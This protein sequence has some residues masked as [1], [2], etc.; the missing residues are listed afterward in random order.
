MSIRRIIGSIANIA[1]SISE[2][3]STSVSLLSSELNALDTSRKIDHAISNQFNTEDKLNIA[4][5]ESVLLKHNCLHKITKK[6]SEAL[7]DFNSL[8][9]AAQLHIESLMNQD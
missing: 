2:A 3:A 7:K 5:T 8:K 9:K 1:D 6:G 4:A